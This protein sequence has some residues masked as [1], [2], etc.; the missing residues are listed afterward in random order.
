MSA[1]SEYVPS[2]ATI[3]DD[4]M[5]L[6]GEAMAV[7]FYSN[8][9]YHQTVTY[10]T[11]F[12]VHDVPSH[13]RGWIMSQSP[14]FGWSRALT[15]SDERLGFVGQTPGNFD[16]NLGQIKI[17]E[18]NVLIGTW[19][20]DGNCQTWLNGVA[21]ANR[22]CSN[23][24][25]HSQ[26]EELIIGGRIPVDGT[27]NPNSIDISHALVYDRELT[28][29]EVIQVVV[30][31]SEDQDHGVIRSVQCGE[32]FNGETH[33]RHRSHTYEY[34]AVS[35]VLSFDSCATEDFDTVLKI[36]D[37]NKDLVFEND[38][39][40]FHSTKCEGSSSSWTSHIDATGLE[41]GKT[42]YLVVQGYNMYRFGH[43]DL[44]LECA[45]PT[46]SPTME[47]TVDPSEAP[48]KS[49][50][51]SPST[52]PS[53]SPT[54]SQPTEYPTNA[55]SKT[56]SK[57]PSK[58]PTPSPTSQPTENPT[59]APSTSPSKSP[60]KAP[61]F[62]PTPSPTSQ[63]TEDPTKAPSK[64]PSKSPSKAPTF[65]PTPSPTTQ[66]T[67]D[68][69]KAPSKSPSESPSKAPTP[70]P[71]DA[72]SNSPTTDSP[73]R[74]PSTSPTVSPTTSSPST[75][76]TAGD[77]IVKVQGYVGNPQDFIDWEM[78]AQDQHRM[79][80]YQFDFVRQL[81]KARPTPP[82]TACR[83]VCE[84]STCEKD[85]SNTLG[86][87]QMLG[88]SNACYVRE[89]GV[90]K[91]ECLRYCNRGGLSG[92]NL[93]IEG[94]AFRLCKHGTIR[95]TMCTGHVTRTD[96]VLGCVNYPDDANQTGSRKL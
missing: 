61:T 81:K 90:S 94:V 29:E 77:F 79:N 31:L 11:R 57:S 12:R 51:K 89:L 3:E 86:A 91:Q 93:T 13:N 18:W 96:C 49:P 14:D 35:T 15:I 85:A 39:H 8:P 52:V 47:P 34:T 10:I 27:H 25:G 38:D 64:S 75:S 21:G 95:G 63:P 9:N 7:P 32:S 83:N 78:A 26:Q 48:S 20:Q 50:S 84:E 92:C 80:A 2:S 71:T 72:P 82:L 45:G 37:E 1:Y 28:D 40:D 87:T 58:A 36:F 44:H 69:T 55:P 74:T 54:T 41:I 88:C 68:P 22:T 17:N 59:K 43:Y 6:S 56:P 73:S 42:Y 5:H 46:L 16:S 66:P 4:H 33:A 62:A 30:G 23:G 67:V 65:G 60:S 19:T 70:S 53:T 24:K 76:P